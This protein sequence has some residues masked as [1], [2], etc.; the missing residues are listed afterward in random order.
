[1]TNLWPHRLRPVSAR[2]GGKYHKDDLQ[3]IESGKRYATI[4][5]HTTPEGESLYVEVRKT[6]LLDSKGRCIGVQGIF[7]D[8]TDRIRIEKEREEA[9]RAA[10]AANQAKSEFLANMSHEIRTPLNGVFGMTELLL[11]NG[12][13]GRAARI[14]EYDS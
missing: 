3:V 11:E 7:W 8:V 12:T 5:E 1:M 9:K 6:P 4:E 14:P 13:I 10:E 2:V